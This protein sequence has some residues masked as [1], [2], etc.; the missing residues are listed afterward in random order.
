MNRAPDLTVRR[1]DGAELST[2]VWQLPHLMRCV[3]TAAVGGGFSE[4]AWVINAQVVSGYH[5]KD[6]DEHGAQIAAAV[7]L[8]GAGV[9]MLTA[10]DVR[11]H[12]IAEHEGAHVTA[13]VGVRVP[14][15]AADPA[16]ESASMRNTPSPA[17]TINVVA[18]V[19]QPVAAAGLVNLVATITEAKCQALADLAVPGTG[20]ASDAV[21]VLCPL[22]GEIESFGGPRSLW[23]AR[24]ANATYDAIVA[25]LRESRDGSA[26]C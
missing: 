10:V 23:G 26:R 21:T 14:T 24:V 25:G 11:A 9:V 16:F 12:H 19:P 13:T 20:T 8:S 1:E 7:G 17:G 3:S 22:D 4:C 2:L 15:W 6:L 5:R 18:S